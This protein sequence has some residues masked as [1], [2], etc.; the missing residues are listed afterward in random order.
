MITV[1]KIL[2]RN[3]PGAFSVA[4]NAEIREI[5]YIDEIK[6]IPIIAQIRFTLFMGYPFCNSNSVEV[7]SS[8]KR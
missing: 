6:M 7:L 2:A 8:Y 5:R 4:K 1:L 3:N